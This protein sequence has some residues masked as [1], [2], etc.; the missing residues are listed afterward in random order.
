M[1]CSSLGR[2]Y[3]HETLYDKFV[4]RFV[5]GAGKIVTGDP[6]DEKTDMG[7]VVSAEHRNRVESYIKA[8]VDEG[9]SLIIGAS[10]L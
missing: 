3:L 6:A 10:V 4:D 2:Y 8:G 1:V 9:A 7:P 5:A